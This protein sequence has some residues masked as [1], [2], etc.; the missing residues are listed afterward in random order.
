[1][2][3]LKKSMSIRSFAFLMAVFFQCFFFQYSIAQDLNKRISIHLK[4]VTYAEALNE[5]QAKSGI[6]FSYSSDIFPSTGRITLKAKNETVSVVLES[7]LQNTG[8]EY[9]LVEKQVVLIRKAPLQIAV[10]VQNIEKR[11]FTISGHIREKG[12]G[13]LIIG[14][15]I[16][17]KQSYKGC[18][19]NAYGYYSLQLTEGTYLLQFSYIGLKPV[20][21]PLELHS[22][23]QLDIELEN[24]GLQLNAVE[25]I[26]DEPNRP[27]S[28]DIQISG[29][30]IDQMTTFAGNFDMIKTLQSMPGIKA[31]GDGSTLLYVRGG[32]SDQNLLLIDEAPVYNASHLFGFFSVMAPDAI[33]EIQV[34]K[35]DIPASAGGRLSSVIDIRAK[36][37]NMQHHS[38]SGNIGPY[39]SSITAQGPVI[40]DEASYITSFRV[41]NLNWL[42]YTLNGN[43]DVKMNFYDFNA[44]VNSRLGRNDR[45]Y[46]TFFSG[47]DN[48][49]RRT[50][51]GIE[52]TGI[53]WNNLAFTVRENHIFNPKL[54][55]NTTFYYS[56]YNYKLYLSSEKDMYWMSAIR[57]MA[58]KTDFSWF[59]NS[60]NTIK[61][62]AEAAIHHFDPGNVHLDTGISEDDPTAVSLY[63]SPEYSVYIQ[64]EQQIGK[65]L[66]FRYGIRYSVWQNMGE[67]DICYFDV[68]HHVIDTLHYGKN[69]VYSTFADYPEPRFMATYEYSDDLRFKAGYSRTVQYMQVISNSTS[70]FTTLDVW[71]PAGPNVEPMRADQISCGVQYFL[72]PLNLEFSSEFYYKKMKGQ[73]DFGD[74]P[75]L[76][77]NPLI[78]GEIRK[79]TAKAWGFETMIRRTR[80]Q[81]TG[82]MGYSFSKVTKSISEV[83]N[84]LAFPASYDRPHNFVCNLS[85]AHRSWTFAADWIYMTGAAV[86]TPVGFY[87]YNGYVVPVYGNKHNSR[88]PDYHRLDITVKY[89]LSRTDARFHH[90]VVL[91]LYNVYNRKNPVSVNFNKTISEENEVVIPGNLASYNL[92]F[93]SITWVSGIIPSINYIFSF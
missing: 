72:N 71:I 36:D 77:Y 30:S 8:I 93:P 5:V 62:G 4:N 15:N 88:L 85:F 41:S 12:S 20:Q 23:L 37:G 32:N 29:K 84:D 47:S 17:D 25:I 1:M 58:L 11:K 19:S 80:G 69:E 92:L 46:L 65:K 78:E 13:E 67:T 45:L 9:K 14:A 7:I 61:A 24:A 54:F 2:L 81:I 16:F 3:H 66:I 26:S 55:A 63:T 60:N 33:K 43:R 56:R 39:A 6:L 59:L 27:A 50:N 75:N 49:S 89:E 86:T 38:V 22:N 64:N 90:E 51:S 42:L 10:P 21:K 68:N 44:K 76:L 31:F 87:K 28:P 53:G 82:W 52:T 73:I 57:N 48:L 40:K 83:N 18:L 70:P 74:H 35:G 91:S 79:G 34:Y